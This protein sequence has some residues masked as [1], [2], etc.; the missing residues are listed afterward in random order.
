VARTVIRNA[1][2]IYT[3]DDTDS[4]LSG[5]DLVIDDDRIASIGTQCDASG[6]DRVIDASRHVV[7]PG[8]VNTHHHFF[9]HTARAMPTTFG[10]TI[11]DWLTDCYVLWAGLDPE[12]VYWSTQAAVAELL[13]SGCTTAADFA[14]LHPN[15]QT[16]LFDEEVRAVREMGI[17][18][19][20]VRGCT[21]TLEEPVA[22]N[23]A[24]AGIDPSQLLETETEIFSRSEKA[25]EDY[26]DPAPHAMIRVGLGP[27]Q[28]HYRSPDFMRELKELARRHDAGTHLHLHPRPDERELVQEMYGMSPLRFLD[29]VGWLDEATWLAHASEHDADDIALLRDRGT[30]VAHCPGCIFRLGMRVTK[31]PQML[32]AGVKVGLGVDGGASN[33]SGNLLAEVRGALMVHRLKGVHPGLSP[34]DWLTPYD[35]FKAATRGGAAVLRRPEIGKLA[36][37]SAADV[38]LIRTDSLAYA[39]AFDPLGALVFG[40]PPSPVDVTIVAGKVLVEN[41]RLTSGREAQIIDGANATAQR[42]A[43]LAHKTTGRHLRHHAM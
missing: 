18:F 15:G 26:H 23:L 21:P 32:A 43:R 20:G 25:I 2:R 4:V 29:S 14:Y 42:L 6:A 3:F 8:L 7:L 16:E 35:V 10:S 19:H 9:Q 33:D 38:V 31:V 24:A 27:T 17:R 36:P 11:I 22:A 34:E 40:S 39:G 41:G 28:T 13:L 37:G 1:Q 30:G 5:V 12:A